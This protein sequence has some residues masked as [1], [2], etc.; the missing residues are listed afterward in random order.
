MSK[1][2]DIQSTSSGREPYEPP[3][4]EE[5]SLRAEESMLISCKSTRQQMGAQGSFT[6]C[7]TFVTCKKS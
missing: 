1:V 3:T 6:S 7:T 5:M 2:S 4:I